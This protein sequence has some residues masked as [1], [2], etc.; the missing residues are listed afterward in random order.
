LLENVELFK[1]F[2]GIKLRVDG[3][4]SFANEYGNLYSYSCLG[5]WVSE[6]IAMRE[7][8]AVWEAWQSRDTDVLR[9]HFKWLTDEQ[10]RHVVCYDFDPG[11]GDAD[12]DR[13][14]RRW[15]V[16]GSESSPD[17]R[18]EALASKDLRVAAEFYLTQLIH[19]RR[20]RLTTSTLIWDHEEERLVN[21]FMPINLLAALWLQFEHFV[22]GDN[23]LLSCRVCGERFEVSRMAGRSDK[24]YCSTACRSKAYR[25]RMLARTMRDEGKSIQEIAQ[26]FATDEGTV[27]DWLSNERKE[28]DHTKK[29]KRKG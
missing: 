20:C 5:D 1:I 27:N 25:Q 23:R 24:E 28:R 18:W 6:V 19:D 14:D 17:G 4:L 16:I 21:V 10:G 12:F 2:S 22:V 3:I 11:K 8:I 29:T 15:Q 7:A 9:R 26:H 13:Q